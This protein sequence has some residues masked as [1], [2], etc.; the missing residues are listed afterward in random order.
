M[1]A[2]IRWQKSSHSQPGGECVELGISDDTLRLRES[3]EPDA[4]LSI[5]RTA[6]GA[7]LDRLKQQG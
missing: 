1:T 3:D 4:V 5:S 7:L 6:L 2:P